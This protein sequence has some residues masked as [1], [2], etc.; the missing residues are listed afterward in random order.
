[1]N[2]GFNPGSVR[3]PLAASVVVA[4]LLGSVCNGPVWGET[5][6]LVGEPIRVPLSQRTFDV[7]GRP[8]RYANQIMSATR[9]LQAL[10]AKPADQIK[11]EPALHKPFYYKLTAGDR[12]VLMIVDIEQDGEKA[13][14][15]ADLDGRGL[16]AESKGVPGVDRNKRQGATSDYAYFQ[17]EPVTFPK[18]EKAAAGPATFAASLFFPKKEINGN[19][20]LR[21]SPQKLVEGMLRIGSVEYP[22]S[23]VDGA[24]IGR[25]EMHQAHAADGGSALQRVYQKGASMM[26]IDLDRNG[27]MD[28]GK[29]ISPLVELVRI[30]GKYYRVGVSPDGSQATFQEVKPEMGVLNTKCAEAELFVISDRCVALLTPNQDGKWELPVGTYSTT[31]FSLCKQEGGVNWTLNGGQQ[32]PAMQVIKIKQGTPLVVEL[33]TPLAMNYSVD[34]EGGGTASIGLSLVGKSGET[35]SAG[36]NK[37]HTQ[38]PQPQ[39]VITDEQ[40]KK[41]TEGKFEYG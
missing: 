32:S 16:L 41:L 18:T 14:L 29:E 11:S 31:S 1:M 7:N 35:Y 2:L 25:Y 34:R 3:H 9:H 19:P 38:Q 12:D 5:E 6:T 22:V 10:H 33:G 26:A 20:A 4:L 13:T 30:D 36:A 8:A 23:F 28:W 40:G 39:F 37:N 17:F 27:M 21:L 24:L 15:Y